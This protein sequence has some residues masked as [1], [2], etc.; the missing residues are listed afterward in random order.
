[1]D[2]WKKNLA[3][4]VLLVLAL[5]NLVVWYAV[6]VEARSDILT[7]AFLDVGQGD[8]IF[9]E[10]PSGRQALIDGGAG[11]VVLRRLGKVMPFF[12]R[13]IDVTV[14]T[15]PDKDHIGGLIDVLESYNITHILDPGVVHDTNAYEEFERLADMEPNAERLLA[16]R[17][18][19]VDFGDG[20][21]LRIL[22]P[23]RDVSGVETN[24]GSII[25]QLV[26]GDTEIMLTGDAP[27]TIEEYLIL[28]D[29]PSLASDVLKAGHHGS[30]TSSSER[31][32]DI[33]D[34]DYTVISAECDS[35][36]GHPHREVLD[37]LT[38]VGTTVL[39]TCD[40]GTIV[41]ESDGKTV[42]VK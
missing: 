19:V 24:A 37:V 10:S 23:D 17:G 13:S 33:V 7:V 8:A 35:R 29:G 40:E 4:V 32:V 38:R 15:H 16:R 5:V 11:S 20:A 6:S 1:M 39:S 2:S 36:Y 34:P 12:D 22:F 27:R 31:F 26:Y 9:I 3:W 41:F 18:Q 30:R 14:A 21:Y 28:R 25:A 42:R